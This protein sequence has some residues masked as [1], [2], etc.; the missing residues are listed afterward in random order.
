M[1]FYFVEN[2]ERT[3]KKGELL[4]AIWTDTYVEETTLARNVSWLRKTPAECA[5]GK[6]F[7]ETV[8]K[9]LGGTERSVARLFS[10]NYSI[11]FSP[12]GKTV[13]FTKTD[14]PTQFWRVPADG[15]A[16]EV[17]PEFETAG[18]NNMWQ[19]TEAGIYFIAFVAD[20]KFVMKFYDFADNQ[21]KNSSGS[22]KIPSNLDTNIFTINETALL[23]PVLEKSSRLMIADLP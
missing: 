11:S 21:I 18:F 7:I 13:Y 5:D 8:P 12:D 9:L 19:A 3:A 23:C 14:F 1:L 4:D 2:A 6:L 22:Y 20:K 15:G 17:M 16:E 10:G